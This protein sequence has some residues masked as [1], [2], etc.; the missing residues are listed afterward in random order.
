MAVVHPRGHARSNPGDAIRLADDSFNRGD[1]D[2]FFSFYEPDALIQFEQ[3]QPPTARA[4]FDLD[5]NR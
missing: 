1:L 3:R 4:S 2:A 5:L